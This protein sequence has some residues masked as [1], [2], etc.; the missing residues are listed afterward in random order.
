MRTQSDE[1]LAISAAGQRREERIRLDLAG[2]QAAVG[3]ATVGF[4][5]IGA[6]SLPFLRVS[7]HSSLVIAAHQHTRACTLC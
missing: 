2:L 5:R 4:L 1:R 7:L 6:L 3:S